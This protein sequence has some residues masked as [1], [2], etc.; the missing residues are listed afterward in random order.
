MSVPVGLLGFHDSAVRWFVGCLGIRVGLPNQT[1]KPWQQVSLH[2]FSTAPLQ[3][4]C[5]SSCI[6]H[7]VGSMEE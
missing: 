6:C 5:L 1:D 4:P 3:R 2:M 7:G